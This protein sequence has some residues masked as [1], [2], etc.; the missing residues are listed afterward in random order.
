[1]D[2]A[3]DKPADPAQRTAHVNIREIG[4]KDLD[5]IHELLCEGFPRRTPEYWRSAIQCLSERAL[6]PECHRYGYLL[7]ADRQPQ[8]VLLVLNAIVDSSIRSNLSSWYVRQP[9]RFLATRMVQVATRPNGGVYLDLSPAAKVL[10]IVKALGFKPYSDGTLFFTPRLLLSSAP[11]ARVTDW[12][13]EGNCDGFYLEDRLGRIKVLYRIKT[14]KKAIP[15]ARFVYGDPKRLSAAGGA[16]A[17]A[18]LKKGIPVA[19]ADAP[20]GFVPPR[21]IIHMPQREIRYSKHGIPPKVG[22]LRESE[23]AL[24][25]P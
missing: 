3:I 5:A 4:A 24:F 6:V 20:V 8:G 13:K 23:I 2:T 14:L 15:A 10:P 16:V 18:L 21:G 25:G 19:M 12:C 1:M 17:R 22:D 7:E 9:F 11:G